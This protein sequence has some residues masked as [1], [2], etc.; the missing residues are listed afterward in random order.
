MLY[1]DSGSSIRAGPELS[2]NRTTYRRVSGVFVGVFDVERVC[3]PVVLVFVAHHGL[4]FCHGV[5]DTFD[6]AVA[7]GGVGACQE[8]VYIEGKDVHP[9][10]FGVRCSL[11]AS[12]FAMMW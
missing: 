4:Y 2:R 11:M 7:T 9:S 1:A 6:A 8:F 3:I 5:V 12:I 10:H